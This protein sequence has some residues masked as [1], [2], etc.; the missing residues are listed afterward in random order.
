MQNRQSISRGQ[1]VF[2]AIFAL[3]FLVGDLLFS[4][5]TFYTDWL[6]FTDLGYES[7]FL[8]SFRAR[9]IA[10]V[11]GFLAFVIPAVASILVAARS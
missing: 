4:A 9:L 10:F 6:W 8:T 1:L 2:L 3:L 5:V 7:V 11:V